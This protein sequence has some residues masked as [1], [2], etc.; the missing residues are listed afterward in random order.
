MFKI[1]VQNS[2]T[3]AKVAVNAQANKICA[4]TILDFMFLYVMYA[5]QSES[6]LF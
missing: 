1:A 5:F 2:K 4:P 3:S 6:T